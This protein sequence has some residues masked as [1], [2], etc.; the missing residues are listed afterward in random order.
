MLVPRVAGGAVLTAPPDA[1]AQHV[2]A[3][4]ALA[5]M[6]PAAGASP[7]AASQAG[8][9]PS[10]YLRTVHMDLSGHELSL[11]QLRDLLLEAPWRLRQCLMW[12]GL[13]LAGCGLKPGAASEG[14]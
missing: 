1:S 3:L 9:P 5:C 11:E 14:G 4:L 8:E 12:H 13:V 10:H 6:R 2:E 7:Q